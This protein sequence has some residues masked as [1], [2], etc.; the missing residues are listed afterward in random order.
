MGK[1]YAPRLRLV[2]RRDLTAEQWATICREWQYRCAYCGR[3]PRI[4]TKDHVRPISRG[5]YHTASNIV[6]ACER[7][8]SRKGNREL[9][10][11]T[12]RKLKTQRQ[13][14]RTRM[15]DAAEAAS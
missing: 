13:A 5:G 7:C 11:A 3:Q 1:P 9:A 4:L 6:P 2:P 8:N 14:V 12:R 15:L 10:P